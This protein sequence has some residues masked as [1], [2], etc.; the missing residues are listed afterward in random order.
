MG[1]VAEAR[2]LGSWV[3]EWVGIPL[4]R[5]FGAAFQEADEKELPPLDD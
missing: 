2:W 4:K 1:S 3:A 5:G